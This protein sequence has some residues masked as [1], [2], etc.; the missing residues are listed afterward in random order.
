MHLKFLRA[1]ATVAVLAGTVTLGLGSTQAALATTTDVACGASLSTAITDA[2]TGDVLVL[3]PDCTY[4]LTSALPMINIDLTIVGHHS[5]WIKR[6][7]AD[8][9][10]SFSIFSV[11]SAGDLTLRGV[12]VAN[13]GGSDHEDGGAVYVN[14]GTL[15]IWGGIFTGNNTTDSG[16][17]IDNFLGSL[18]VYGATF[19]RNSSDYGGAIYSQEDGATIDG[20]TFSRNEA[21]E[22]GAIYNDDVMTL[23]HDAIT[24]NRA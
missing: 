24:G 6:S 8:D 17:A 10:P 20:T 1:A 23:N 4:W 22:G 19:T 2:N 14:S 5:T 15:T 16:G 7:Y 13:G 12:N 3:A 18:S 11:C 9:T 21:Y